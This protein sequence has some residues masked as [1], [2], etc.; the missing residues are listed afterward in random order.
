MSI[1][2]WFELVMCVV[3]CQIVFWTAVSMIL[4]A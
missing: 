1:Q 2:D 3:V 4:S